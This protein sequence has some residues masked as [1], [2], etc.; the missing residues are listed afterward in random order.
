MQH[1]HVPPA[2]RSGCTD[3]LRPA[4]VLVAFSRTAFAH[5][6]AQASDRLGQAFHNK[7]LSQCDPAGLE[8]LLL[9]RAPDLR[10][11]PGQIA[12]PGGRL[13]PG[14]S[15]AQGALREA[16]EETGMDPD[17]V[18][19][20]QVLSPLPMVHSRHCITP[21]VAWWDKTSPI[22]AVD[23][24]ETASVF[25]APLAALMSASN[26]Y[27]WQYT[28]PEGHLRQGPAWLI[29]APDVGGTLPIPRLIWGFTAG[30]LDRIM[31]GYGWN[32][33]WDRQR[34]IDPRVG[35]GQMHR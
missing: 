11:H 14:E 26:R 27:T 19:I 5:A 21:V 6:R 1:A 33:P 28:S 8:V 22:T 4:A 12:F 35:A 3:T 34:I 30:L 9:E 24:R 15:A 20:C 25:Y 31:E 18:T 7:Q 32:Q 16:R 23:S 29:D 17:G 13:E 2:D 10:D